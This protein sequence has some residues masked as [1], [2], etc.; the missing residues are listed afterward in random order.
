MAAPTVE[1]SQDTVFVFSGKAYGATKIT[2][3]RGGG[4]TSSGS[5]SQID[6]SDLR[7]ATGANKTYQSPPLAEVTS[8]GGTG[9]V[10]TIDIDFNGHTRPPL[11]VEAAIDL[12]SKLKI[13]GKAKCDSYQIDLQ[14]N[15]IIR[16]SATFSLTSVDATYTPITPTP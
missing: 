5:A 2:E 7:L 4:S 11:N 9:V 15:D 16:G 1:N 3:K 10:A 13:S 14:V 8:S 12:G 6:T